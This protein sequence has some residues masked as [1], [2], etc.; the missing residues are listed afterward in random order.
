MIKKIDINSKEFK[1]EL[2]NTILFTQQV[3]NEYNLAFNP[4]IEINE[5]IQMGLT[6]NQMIYGKR[7]CPCFMVVEDDS[8]NRL[9]PCVPALTKEIPTN[10]NCHCGIY[11]TKEKAKELLLNIDTKEAIAT[12]F[13]GLTKSECEEL[14]NQSDISAIEL[15]ALLE[16]RKE[17]VISFLL[18]D[19]REWMEWVGAR[20]RG[21]D[22]LIPTTSFYS[23]LEAIN[24]KKDIPIIVYCHSGSRSKY[25][26]KIMLDMG[27]KK[28][29][30]LDYGI[31]SFSGEIAQGE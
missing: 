5:S 4:D 3:V 14:L 19:T 26:Q 10:G 21:T 6:R 28:V 13:R 20:I 22:Y 8:E 2:Q 12:N 30:N 1:E 18:V 9:C 17:G 7:Y 31:M 25:C 16:A 27:F 15:E 29:T 23:S 24:D 11:C